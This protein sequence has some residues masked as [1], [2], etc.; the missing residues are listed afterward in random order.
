MRIASIPRQAV[1]LSFLRARSSEAKRILLQ[2]KLSDGREVASRRSGVGNW[3]QAGARQPAK[4]TP[5]GEKSVRTCPG[6]MRTRCCGQPSPASIPSGGGASLRG[7]LPPMSP[8]RFCIA[9]CRGADRA[10]RA[11]L[12]AIV[13]RGRAAMTAFSAAY[14]SLLPVTAR[15][16]P[17]SR[18]Q[19]LLRLRR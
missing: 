16:L 13:V 6:P 8:H 19:P 3:A 10:R 4:Y 7:V 17:R 2:L 9:P 5:S 18:P 12:T 1:K 14:S 15:P 11:S